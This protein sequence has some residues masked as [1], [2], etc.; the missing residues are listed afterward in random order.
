[1]K[2][3]AYIAIWSLTA[4]VCA[5]V[6]RAQAQ[7]PTPGGQASQLSAEITAGP[8]LGHESSSFVAG[9]VGWRVRPKLEVFV[10]GGHMANVATSSLEANANV[11]APVIGQVGGGTGS[12]S[13]IGIKVNHI[14]AGVKYWIDPIDPRFHPYFLFGIGAAFATTE[15]NFALNGNV[16][17]PANYG[18]QL[19]GDLSGTN[20]KT[21]ISF[22]GGIAIPFASRYFF[23][24]GYRF[25]GILS[26]TSDIENDT[27]IKSQRIILGVGARF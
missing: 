11:I 14:G 22:G 20:T 10:E 8:T 27:A 6:P 23:D 7:P 24:L 2:R 1:M 16:V 9:E 26:K 19:G 21:M 3:C 25:G 17:D 18:V 15:V 13:S 12:V 5:G 4:F